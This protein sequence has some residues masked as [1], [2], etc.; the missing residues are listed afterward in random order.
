M[1][2]VDP[3]NKLRRT[4]YG[5][6]GEYRPQPHGFEYRTPSNFWLSS[7]PLA[8]FIFGAARL[9]LAIYQRDLKDGSLTKKFAELGITESEVREAINNNDVALATVIFAK[10]KPFIKECVGAYDGLWPGMLDNFEWFAQEVQTKGLNFF[11]PDTLEHWCTL[12]EAHDYGWTWFMTDKVP[13]M[14][15]GERLPA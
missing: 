5:R 2:D 13:S 9:A 10:L 11:W 8:G 12:P 7:G 6:A 4:M 15:R 14:R 1:I 3:N